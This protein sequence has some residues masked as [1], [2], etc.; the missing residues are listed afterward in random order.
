MLW[1]HLNC[2]RWDRNALSRFV[3]FFSPL[4]AQMLSLSRTQA[5]HTPSPYG[6]LIS[7]LYSMNSSRHGPCLEPT[8]FS[9]PALTVDVIDI[10]PRHAKNCPFVLL[11]P[12]ASAS[13]YQMLQ[14]THQHILLDRLLL[15]W[16]LSLT[17]NLFSTCVDGDC[18]DSPLADEKLPFRRYASA[19][20]I[21]I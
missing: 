21:R 11:W 7:T 14:P 13:Y 4:T 3:L 5:F 9:P 12:H 15:P 19:L 2:S 17:D 16:T 20:Y 10:P 6:Q 8:T 1:V 18:H